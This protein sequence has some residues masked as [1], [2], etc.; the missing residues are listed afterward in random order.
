[1]INEN[2]YKIIVII[3]AVCFCNAETYSQIKRERDSRFI[4][5]IGDYL[6]P[7]SF[8]TTDGDVIDSD[9]FKGQIS[10]IQ[11][12]AS[13]C[14]FSREQL[15]NIEKKIWSKY[16]NNPKFNFICFCVDVESDKVAFKQI[17]EDE[18][19]TFPISYDT[20]ETIYRKFVTPQGSVT[21]TIIFNEEGEII[22]LCDS[23]LR[24]NFRKTC[25]LIEKL[26]PK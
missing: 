7:L 13:W 22:Y 26:L 18:N 4:V 10:M 9:F 24:K 8:E 20:D 2:I 19:L 23:H 16:Q 21:R 1:M 17:I 12:A 6:P 3:I 14:P 11:F 5:S 15:R 25:R